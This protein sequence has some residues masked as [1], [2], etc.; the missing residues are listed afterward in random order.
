V[1]H[2]DLCNPCGLRGRPAAAALHELPAEGELLCAIAIGEEAEIANAL[3][4]AGQYV[5][6]EAADEFVS[7]ERHR[8][9]PI[10][11]AIILS[12]KR[13]PAVTDI[14]QAIVGDGDTVRV[15]SDILEDF[16]RSGKGSL[17]V[18]HPVLFFGWE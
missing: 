12:A 15:P 2:T 1:P 5:Q 13:D 18:D 8:L 6:E 10:A 4:P 7:T 9:V 11:I 16:F 17:G 14:G 3:E